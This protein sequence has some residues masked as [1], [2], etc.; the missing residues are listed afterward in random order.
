MYKI[1]KKDLEK[2]EDQFCGSCK[3]KK[4]KYPGDIMGTI[5]VM[6]R[7]NCDCNGPS[8][9]GM[10]EKQIMERIST[11]FWLLAGAK[12]KPH[13]AKKMEYMKQHNLTWTDMRKIEQR[14]AQP[15]G[16]LERFQNHK[17]GRES[18]KFQ[19]SR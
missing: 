15:N 12:P 14:N 11:P 7:P 8:S 10:T 17:E 1:T 16:A 18:A 5:A 6:F 3:T 19:T 2:A 4:T 13:E 9:S